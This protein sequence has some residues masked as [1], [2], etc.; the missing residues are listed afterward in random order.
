MTT[1]EGQ[2]RLLVE[3]QAEGLDEHSSG[4]GHHPSPLL[5][6]AHSQ[7]RYLTFPLSG[8][9]HPTGAHQDQRCNKS[10]RV[11]AQRSQTDD[12]PEVPRGQTF[13]RRIGV[14]ADG[15]D[16]AVNNPSTQS[17]CAATLVTSTVPSD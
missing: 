15:A 6:V 12:S 14:D 2:Q 8:S 13:R 4:S 7:S 17:W 10:G 5:L 9:S 3:K 1:G 11:A 16:E